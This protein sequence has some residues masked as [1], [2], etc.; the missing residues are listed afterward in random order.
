[1]T[2]QIVEAALKCGA[3]RLPP[4]PDPATSRAPLD[5][6]PGIPIENYWADITLHNFIVEGSEADLIRMNSRSGV[7]EEYEIK[8][9]RSDLLRECLI[10]CAALAGQTDQLRPDDRAKYRKHQRFHR[11]EAHYPTYYSFA[12]PESLVELALDRAPYYAGIVAIRPTARTNWHS[13]DRVRS[14][15]LVAVGKA[16][17]AFF[18]DAAKHLSEQYSS[19][20]HLAR[21]IRDR[22]ARWHREFLGNIAKA[23]IEVE[24]ELKK[25]DCWSKEAVEFLVHRAVSG[26]TQHEKDSVRRFFLTNQWRELDLFDQDG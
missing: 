5:V 9:A 19:I 6:V 11:R 22:E 16:D 20:S 26:K 4:D 13:A 3:L 2:T 23:L 15:E 25:N 12:L 14:P 17:A 24:T 8:V 18:A 1:M 7:I 10:A 21:M